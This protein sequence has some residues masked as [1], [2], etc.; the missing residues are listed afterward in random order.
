[1][2]DTTENTTTDRPVA[3]ITGVGRRTGIAAGLAVALAADG[4]DLALSWWGPYDE[5]VHGGADPEG[6]ESVIGECTALGA[7]VARVPVDLADADQ[8]AGLVPRA[9]EELGRTVSAIVMSHAE[10]VV[11]SIATTSAAAFDRHMAVNARAPFLMIQAYAEA[12]RADDE[13]ADAAAK[14][15]AEAEA[16]AEAPASATTAAPRDR[17]RVIALT[18]DHTAHNLPYGTSKGALDRL[19]IAA[20]SELGDL[21]VRA[22]VLNPGPIDTGWMDDAIRASG[23]SD[24]PA[25]RL[26]TPEDIG[27]YVAFLCSPAGGWINGQLL[28]ADGGFSSKG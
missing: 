7:R 20:A 9:A 15:E 1:M 27:A 22:N 23:A 17:R 2:P 26:G 16:E 18:S 5:R 12:L 10:C 21:D 19:V 28:F 24:T 4:W 25:G 14:A 13:A 11:T 6:V 3:L 8:A